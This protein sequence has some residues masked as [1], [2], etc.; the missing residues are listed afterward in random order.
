M[1]KHLGP[2]LRN[3]ICDS[4]HCSSLSGGDNKP[5]PEFFCWAVVWLCLVMCLLRRDTQWYGFKSLVRTRC[6]DIDI[7]LHEGRA[8]HHLLRSFVAVRR[9]GRGGGP[10]SWVSAGTKGSGMIV[11]KAMS[12]GS[13]SSGRG[14]SSGTVTWMCC[15]RLTQRSVEIHAGMVVRPIILKNDMAKLSMFGIDMI[16][17]LSSRLSGPCPMI[18]A[19]T[20]GRWRLYSLFL[21]LRL[22]FRA[23]SHGLQSYCPSRRRFIPWRLLHVWLFATVMTQIHPFP[24]VI[25]ESSPSSRVYV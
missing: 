22:F 14:H 8:E 1:S 15:S 10:P 25:H 11:V 6:T 4:S 12:A 16:R 7:E 2:L 17:R 21:H 23:P 5:D 19:S 3:W 9:A 20:H 18:P 13:D 24:R